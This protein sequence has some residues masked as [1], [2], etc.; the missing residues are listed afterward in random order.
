MR[1]S[2]NHEDGVIRILQYPAGNEQLCHDRN[3]AS[4]CTDLNECMHANSDRQCS[5]VF[6]LSS[7]K[8]LLFVRV[9]VACWLR[10]RPRG[11]LD[12]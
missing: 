9:L 8:V 4:R 7:N 11:W 12:Y 3:E 5:N 6:R 1:R 2:G 10:P